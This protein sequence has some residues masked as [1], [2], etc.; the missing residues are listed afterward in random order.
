MADAQ[1]VMSAPK[2][3]TVVANI[4]TLPGGRGAGIGDNAKN[5]DMDPAD[6][7]RAGRD[8]YS[9]FPMM[10]EP[11]R[12]GGT[13]V[14]NPDGAWGARM[15]APAQA[16]AAML[17]DEQALPLNPTEEQMTPQ[18]REQMKFAGMTLGLNPQGFDNEGA[19]IAAAQKLLERHRQRAAKYDTIPVV[20]GGYRATPNAA[21]KQKT[22]D[23]E[24]YR[25]TREFIRTYPFSPD[26]SDALQ[27][28]LLEASNAGNVAKVAELKKQIRQEHEMSRAQAAKTFTKRQTETSL[29]NN[30]NVAPAMFRESLA[31]AGNDPAAIAAVY[32][33]FGM[34]RQADQVLARE[35]QRVAVEGEARRRE[36]EIGALERKGDKDEGPLAGEVIGGGM[37]L[38]L[39][40]AYEDDILVDTP[41]LTFMTHHNQVA[42]KGNEITPEEA[43]IRLARNMLATNPAA[44]WNRPV[45]KVALQN[46]A[47]GYQLNKGSWAGATRA[48]L[49]LATGGLVND[50]RTA[51]INEVERKLGKGL[52]ER[53]GQW[54]DANAR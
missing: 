35:N 24:R 44:A 22:A 45:V 33:Q 27:Q 25:A 53:A 41:I 21:T 18:W 17:T 36:A 16:Q 1:R 28:K 52:A 54:W 4:D 8:V 15:P 23:D 37:Q 11:G 42:G 39:D 13:F 38:A 40:Q 26:G 30:P 12:R 10:N 43:A 51:F 6:L 3:P 49:N 34:S 2:T 50:R 9:G 19:F 32:R 5:E 7:R 14:Q 20:T 29:M 48:G 47:K 31:Q 46:I